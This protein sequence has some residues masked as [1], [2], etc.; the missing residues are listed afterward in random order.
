MSD[1]YPLIIVDEFQDTNADEW[2]IIQLLG[3]AST[4]V[5]SADPDQRIYEFRGASPAR[6]QEFISTFKPSIFDFSADNHRS[7]GTDIITFAT[8]FLASTHKRKRYSNVAIV[9]Y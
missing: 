7:A 6:I 9:R 8:D 2:D 4:I 3:Q 5:A 1:S